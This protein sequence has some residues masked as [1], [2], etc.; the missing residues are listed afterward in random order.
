MAS[1]GHCI[2]NLGGGDYRLSWVVDHKCA[3]SRLRFPRVHSRLTD[4]E[5]AVRFALKHDVHKIPPSLQGIVELRRMSKK[6][7]EYVEG[8]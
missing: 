6:G 7:R 2:G 1:Y 3:G 5:G 4:V 8:P